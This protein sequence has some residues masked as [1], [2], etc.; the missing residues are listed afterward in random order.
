MLSFNSIVVWVPV[1][2]V[3]IMSRFPQMPRRRVF[4]GRVIKGVV[5]HCSIA[6]RT[7]HSRVTIMAAIFTY[8][9]YSRFPGIGTIWEGQVTVEASHGIHRVEFLMVPALACAISGN[10]GKEVELNQ[11]ESG[12]TR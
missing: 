12:G 8:R 3:L 7:F 11:I 4:S 1:L 5:K 9:I 2:L 6:C 10:D